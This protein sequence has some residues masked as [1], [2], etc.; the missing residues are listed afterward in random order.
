MDQPTFTDREREIIDEHVGDFVKDNGRNPDRGELIEVLADRVREEEAFNAG[1]AAEISEIIR[2]YRLEAGDD[3]ALE[4]DD[5]AAF[6]AQARAQLTVDDVEAG[7]DNPEWG[8][9]G[10]LG[11]RSRQRRSA[12]DR[13]DAFLL[14]EA[15]RRGWTAAQLFDFV[16]S[17][18][19]R[20]FGDLVFG[21][22][23]DADVERQLASFDW[24]R[25]RSFGR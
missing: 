17:G 19:G 5:L 14:R 3:P 25:I 10:Y 23:S 12:Q 24:L 1:I 16:N 15:N 20:H 22:W 6:V 11:E 9:Y 4:G 21:G 18:T 13:G 2:K 8:G 7:L